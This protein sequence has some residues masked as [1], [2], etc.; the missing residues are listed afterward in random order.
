MYLSCCVCTTGRFEF[1]II[2][3]ILDGH[4][5]SRRLHSGS[6]CRP[7]PDSNRWIVIFIV[8]VG[9]TQCFHEVPLSLGAL[10]IQYP[11]TMV[12][13]YPRE[14]LRRLQPV[15]FRPPVKEVTSS[16]YTYTQSLHDAAAPADFPDH[17]FCIDVLQDGVTRRIYRLTFKSESSRKP[18]PINLTTNIPRLNVIIY[19]G[20]WLQR[21][22]HS[23]RV[24]EWNLQNDQLSCLTKYYTNRDIQ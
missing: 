12:A 6:N 2:P 20:L 18:R 1:V 10:V 23:K 15:I 7:V 21:L 11:R 3:N 4:I 14:L 17:Y 8:P 9:E 22:T 16:W 19:D 13:D 24:K 5:W